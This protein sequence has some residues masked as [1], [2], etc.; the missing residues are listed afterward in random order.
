MLKSKHCEICENQI[1]DKKT[2]TKCGITNEKPKFGNKC[3]KIFFDKKYEE[4]ILDTNIEYEKNNN[5]KV[6]K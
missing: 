4:K 3:D 1:T 2:G 5:N 6:K